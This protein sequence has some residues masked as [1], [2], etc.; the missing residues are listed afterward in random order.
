MKKLEGT[1]IYVAE[2]DF[3][4]EATRLTHHHKNGQKHMAR[5]DG[6]VGFF[7]TLDCA[8]KVLTHQADI[9]LWED[10]NCEY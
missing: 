5:P 10:H 7:Y 8:W 3:K 2:R 6:Y 9:V 1:N 4:D